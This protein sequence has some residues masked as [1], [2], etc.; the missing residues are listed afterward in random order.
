MPWIPQ[1]EID[2]LRARVAELEATCDRLKTEQRNLEHLFKTA[3]ARITKADAAIAAKD[4][5][6]KPLA[7]VEIAD[8]DIDRIGHYFLGIGV[9]LTTRHVKAARA[10]LSLPP[11]PPSP[12]PQPLP[13]GYEL[14]KGRPTKV[15]NPDR[16]GW[17]RYHNH[18]DSVGYCDNPARGY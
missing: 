5:A 8:D 4:A 12:E 11:T 13:P 17:F 3:L 18:Y 16:D 6:L 10:A 14:F 2:S 7:D 1:D 9:P 15:L